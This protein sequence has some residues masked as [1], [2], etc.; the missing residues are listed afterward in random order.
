MAYKN[1]PKF[2]EFEEW[3][4]NNLGFDPTDKA[5]QN[6]TE[7]NVG[8]ARGLIQQH[9]FVTRIQEFVTAHQASFSILVTSEISVTTKVMIRRK[10]K[11]KN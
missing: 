7:L 8:S 6:W 5:V 11:S 1:K 3:A 9:G 2:E 4:K 10:K